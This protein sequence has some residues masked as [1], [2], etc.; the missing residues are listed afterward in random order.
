MDMLIASIA[1]ANDLIVVTNNEKEFGRITGLRIE[2]WK[3]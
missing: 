3:N 2:N 1:M